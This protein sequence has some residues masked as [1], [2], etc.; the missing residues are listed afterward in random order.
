MGV[1][2]G[3]PQLITEVELQF[4]AFIEAALQQF[5]HGG[6]QRVQFHR[7][8]IQRLAPGECQQA[9]GQAGGTIG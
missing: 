2:L 7:L 3:H 8:G 1:G 6:D 5:T 9:V 4:D